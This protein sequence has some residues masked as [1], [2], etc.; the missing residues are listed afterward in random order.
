MAE[1][2]VSVSNSARGR[3]YGRRLF[4]HAGM[5]AR[6]RQVDRLFIHAL[7]ENDVMLG[8]AR[9]AGARVEQIG[10]ESEAYLR[11]LPPRTLNR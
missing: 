8:I 7:S 9:K 6:N 3:G 1:F 2:A 5:H 4:A 11:L 10:S